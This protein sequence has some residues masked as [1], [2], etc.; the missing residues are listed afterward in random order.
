[1]EDEMS[2]E[3]GTHGSDVKFLQSFGRKIWKDALMGG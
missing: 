1:M 2:W 3:C